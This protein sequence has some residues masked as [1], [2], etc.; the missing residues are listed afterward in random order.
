MLNLFKRQS[1]EKGHV[2]VY[3]ELNVLIVRKYYFI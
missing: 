1:K 2:T 3:K